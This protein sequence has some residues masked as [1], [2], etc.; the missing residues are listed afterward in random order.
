MMFH[1]EDRQALQTLPDNNTITPEDQLTSA[2][3][4]NAIQTTIKED[5]HFWHFRDELLREVRQESHKRIHTLNNRIT[6]LINCCNFTGY[7]N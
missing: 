1:G 4:L 7:M 5:E 2:C 3:A 6:T